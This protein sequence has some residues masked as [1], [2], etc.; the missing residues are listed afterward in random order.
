MPKRPQMPH[1]DEDHLSPDELIPTGGTWHGLLFGEEPQLT[2][3][4]E[5]TYAAV[6]RSWATTTPNLMVEWVPL[7]DATWMTMAGRTARSDAPAEPIAASAYFF[8][9]HPYEAVRLQIREQDGPR[10]L[11]AATIEG[12]REGLGIPTWNVEAWLDFTGIYVQLRDTMTPESA[13]AVLSEFTDTAGL[14]AVDNGHNV[15]FIPA[16]DA[17]R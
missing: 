12:D 14:E 4:F 11:V 9:H 10:L 2:W 6:E 7:P 17:P 15:R 5:F 13:T 16:D 8:D 1:S 3:S